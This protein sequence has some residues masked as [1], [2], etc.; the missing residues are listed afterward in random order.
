[1]SAHQDIK[2]IGQHAKVTSLS[3]LGESGVFGHLLDPGPYH[4]QELGG[5]AFEEYAKNVRLPSPFEHLKISV[6]RVGSRTIL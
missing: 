4:F 6:L 1:M 5:R 2:G 3:H